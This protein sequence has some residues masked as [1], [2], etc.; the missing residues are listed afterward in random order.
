[1]AITAQYPLVSTAKCEL[2]E[3]VIKDR[4][5]PGFLIVTGFTPVLCKPLVY[6]RL[7]RVLVTGRAFLLGKPELVVRFSPRLAGFDMALIAGNCQVRTDKW[8]CRAVMLT[9]REIRRAESLHRVA[10]LTGAAIKAL[11]KLAIMEIGVA[12]GALGEAG[13]LFA[14]GA[15]AFV[16]GDPNVSAAQGIASL[17][18][19]ELIALHIAPTG[20]CVATGAVAAEPAIMRVPVAI[21]AGAKLQP[22]ELLKT[23]VCGCRSITFHWMALDTLHFLV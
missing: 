2:C 13:H 14:L 1:M 16:A 7:V 20:G 6:V 17:V 19:V 22:R 3:I 11:R 8:K 9:H 15:V 10:T 18:M 12:V 4:H 23:G 5:L 21:C